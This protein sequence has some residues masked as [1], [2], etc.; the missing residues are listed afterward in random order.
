MEYRVHEL[1]QK[2]R[3][4]EDD[5]KAIVES[6]KLL[7][8]RINVLSDS[9]EELNIRLNTIEDIIKGK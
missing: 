9:T 6:I 1:E 7:K 5:I 8:K 3:K 4:Q 2:I